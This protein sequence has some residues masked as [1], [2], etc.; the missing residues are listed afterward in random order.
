MKKFIGLALSLVF[1]L[2]LFSCDQAPA[3]EPQSQQPLTADGPDKLKIFSDFVS[4]NLNIYDDGKLSFLHLSKSLIYN[5][6][7]IED[8]LSDNKNTIIADS[9]PLGQDTF[10]TGSG[11]FIKDKPLG[12]HFNISEEYHIYDD[13][14]AVNSA[15]LFITHYISGMALPFEITFETDIDEALKMITVQS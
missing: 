10:S 8:S 15:R 14:R 1:I 3:T 6:P 5:D 2:T 13:G 11:L 9:F 7:A 12:E 4:D